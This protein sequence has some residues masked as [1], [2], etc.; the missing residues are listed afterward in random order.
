MKK[1]IYLIV[2]IVALGLIIAGCIPVVPHLEENELSSTVSKVTIVS[3]GGEEYINAVTNGHK[4]KNK[5]DLT[6]SFEAWSNYNWGGLAQNAMWQYSIHI[7]EAVNG[8]YSVGSIRF[9]TTTNTGDIEVIGHVKQTKDSTHWG[10]YDLAAAGIAEYEDNIYNFFFISSVS[11][12]WFVLT[13]DAI[14]DHWD[15]STWFGFNRLFQLYSGEGCTFTF[16][17]K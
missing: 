1:L 17:P 4:I 12:I 15:S 10:E 2:A 7:K 11:R 16:E 14:E 8:D 13:N 9:T 5:W 6:G 3:E